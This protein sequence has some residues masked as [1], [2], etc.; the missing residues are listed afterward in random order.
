ME[1]LSPIEKVKLIGINSP[2]I[3]GT[4]I[5]ILQSA[6]MQHFEDDKEFAAKTHESMEDFYKLLKSIDEKLKPIS[7]TYSTVSSLGKWSMALLVALSLIAGIV[8]AVFE[9]LIYFKK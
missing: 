1:N 7:E 4:P 8:Y 2:G 3:H 9:I 5:E 6:M